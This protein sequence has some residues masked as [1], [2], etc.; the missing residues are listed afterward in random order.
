MPPHIAELVVGHADIN[1]TMGYKAVYNE[2]VIT[3]HRA[4]IARRRAIRPVRN[5]APPATPSGTTFLATS[6]DE[7]SHR[8]CGRSFGTHDPRARLHPLPAAAPRPS[9]TPPGSS[10]SATT[11]TP[12]SK[13]CGAKVGPVRPKGCRSALPELVTSWPKPIRSPHATP[14]R[15]ARLR[16]RRRS[17]HYHPEQGSVLMTMT[18]TDQLL[19]QLVVGSHVEATTCLAVAAAIEHDDRTLLIAA[20]DDASHPSESGLPGP[21]RRD[22]PP[23][24]GPRRH[25]HHRA[26]SPRRYRLRRPSRPSPRRRDRPNICAHHHR[27]RPR[28]GLPLGEHRPSLEQRPHHRV[29]HPR[30]HRRPPHPHDNSGSPSHRPNPDL[31]NCRPPSEPTPEAFSAPRPPLSC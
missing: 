29:Q 10:R 4:F 6:S 31:T 17:P 11:C 14:A 19:H 12:G 9:P 24:V 21:A 7:R 13:K 2:E 22:A 27:R 16:Q 18:V 20:T 28:P 1:T 26:R 5:T 23:R 3:A 30:R 8:T 15:D 25:L